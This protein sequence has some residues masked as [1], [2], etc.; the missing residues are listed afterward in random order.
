LREGVLSKKTMAASI[1]RLTFVS[2]I[3][4]ARQVCDAHH[5]QERKLDQVRVV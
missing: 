4:A 2:D 1:V 5:K 3:S